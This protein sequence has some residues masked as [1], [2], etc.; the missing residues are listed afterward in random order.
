METP[1]RAVHWHLLSQ[2]KLAPGAGAGNRVAAGVLFPDTVAFGGKRLRDDVVEEGAVVRDEE[3]GAGV[4]LQRRFEELERLDVEVVGRLVEHEHVGGLGEEPREQAVALAAGKH[5][6]LRVRAARREEEVAEV[7][8][9]VPA[10]RRGGRP[11]RR[12]G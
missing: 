8:H 1:A 7:A 9:H 4:V 6:H 12:R 5:L 3:D 2:L 11:S 10:R